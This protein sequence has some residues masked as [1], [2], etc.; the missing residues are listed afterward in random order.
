MAKSTAIVA[1][2]SGPDVTPVRREDLVLEEL[3]GEAILYDPRYGAVHRF[4]AVT[5]FVWDLCDGS[6]TI[7]DIAQRLTKLCEFNPVEALDGVLRVIAELSTLDLVQGAP[8]EPMNKTKVPW[9]TKAPEP[10]ASAVR[11]YQDGPEPVRLSRRELLRGGVTKLAF[12]AP[13]IA[14]FF[15]SGA[16]ASGGNGLFSFDCKLNGFSCTA[17]GDCCQD[18]AAQDCEFN[19]CCKPNGQP[20]DTDAECCSNTC[21]AVNCN[22]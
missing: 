2:E 12:A 18:P 1:E 19:E 15:A 17:D 9:W 21:G 14:T 8:V 5:L 16:Y 3:D 11:T 7:T 4:N 10:A 6:R 13:V 20:C 22:A